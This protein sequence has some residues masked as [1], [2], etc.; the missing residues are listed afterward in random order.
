MILTPVFPDAEAPIDTEA[1]DARALLADRYAPPRRRWLR[2]N[3]IT[4]VDGSARDSGGTSDGL[5]GRADRVL[6]GAIRD[7]SDTVLVGATTIRAEG[8]LVP[9]HAHLTIVTGSGDFTRADLRDGIA[10]DR[11]LIVGPSGAEPAARRTFSAPF[12]FLALEPHA[13]GRI[14]IALLLRSLADRG[15]DGV[16]CEGGPR[17]AAQLLDAG[18][19]DEICLSTSPQLVGG[20]F[21]ALGSASRETVP[22]DLA[23][24]MVD[25]GGGL[26]ARWRVRRA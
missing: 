4:S 20:G 14:P 15:V 1:P 3:L 18:A 6:L 9:R 13:D 8:S 5:G 23:G 10:P 2:L 21:P 16:V 25:D 26:Y 19:V 17:L 7:T 24:L 12:E 22:L 11:I